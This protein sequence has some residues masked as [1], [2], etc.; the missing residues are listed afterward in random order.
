MYTIYADGKPLYTPHLFHEGYGVFSPKLTVELGKAG[1]LEYT[2][3]PNH[4]MYDEVKKLKSIIS[5]HQGEEEIFRGRVLHDEK[6]FYKQKK[7][8][9]EGE[10]AFLLDAQ[11][12]PYVFSGTPANLFRQLITNYNAIVDP[13]KRFA[14][15]QITIDS[16][17]EY[18]FENFEYS[19][20]LDEINYQLIDN[21]GGF[22]KTRTTN[23]IRCIDWLVDVVNDSDQIIEFGQNL[24][25]ITEYISAENVYTV[26]IPLGAA[27][28]DEEG[29]PLGKLDI[30]SVNDGY[31]YVE[32]DIGVALFGRIERVE[33]FYEIEE[34]NELK[35]IGEYMLE[36]NL[37][38]SITLD[39]KAIDLH[40]LNVDIDKIRLGD[41]VRVLSIPHGIDRKFQCT[42]IV[43][44]LFNPDKNEYIFGVN[45][46]SLTEKQVNGEKTVQTA[47]TGVQ[48]AAASANQAVQKV[49]KVIADIPSAGNILKDVY[50]I[51]S[52]Y[53]STSSVNP[54]DVF[55]FGT[56]EQISQGRTLFGAGTLNDKTYT[57]GETGGEA[58][59]LLTVNEIPAHNHAILDQTTT[60]SSAPTAGAGL[61]KTDARATQGSKYWWGNTMETGGSKPHN[62]LPPYLVVYIWK[63]TA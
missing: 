21:F 5:V 53:I 49:E 19:V 36:A 63:R 14:I 12:R 28:Y 52:V 54:K 47:V 57:G 45:Y 2:L 29:N 4:K 9:C 27:L 59:H 43:Y 15:G 7:T 46:T 42:K 8:Y 25:D 35:A 26:V 32:S 16:D 61:A 58:E 17:E 6:D 11:Q 20:M 18:Y 56:W 51:G 37:E 34:P 39:V 33:E 50:P 55:G 44:D 22:L 41:Y 30:T 62:N 10:L 40:H 23:G 31:D 1:S 13:E 48:S 38:M 24:L 3:P 60:E